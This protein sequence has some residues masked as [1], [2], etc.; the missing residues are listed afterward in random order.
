MRS[1][2]GGSTIKIG[3]YSRGCCSDERHPADAKIQ[4]QA[5]I[6]KKI[7]PKEAVDSRARRQGMTQ[8]RKCQ[9]LL[10]QRRELV[11]R[12]ARRK[13]DPAP[14]SDLNAIW[15]EGGIVANSNQQPDVHQRARRSRIEGQP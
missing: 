10:P 7:Q 12:D 3:R 1:A 4:G 11:K 15:R 9:A 6:A 13:L 5:L 8:D 2:L 14:C